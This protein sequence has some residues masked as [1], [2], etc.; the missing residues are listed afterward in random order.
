MSKITNDVFGPLLIGAFFNAILYG[1]MIMQTFVYYQ[2]YRGD[3]TWIRL[4][5][6]YLFITETINIGC[7]IAA[8]YEPLITRWGDVHA[9]MFFPLMIVAT[10]VTNVAISTPVQFFTAWRIT[11]IS[12]QKWLGALIGVFSVVS[13]I[14]GIWSA[15]TLRVV[16]RFDRKPTI[17]P[18]ATVWFAASSIADA[19]IT[20]ILWW[21]LA[22]RRTG[23]KN[24][25]VTINRIIRLTVQT[26]F[27]TVV[28]ALMELISFF[29]ILNT[30]ANFAFDF[31]LSKLYTNALLSTLN[32]RKGWTIHDDTEEE[33]V[34]FGKET[35][36][37]VKSTANSSHVY[38]TSLGGRSRGPGQSEIASYEMQPTTRKAKEGDAVRV[39]I[40]RHVA[41]DYESKGL[42]I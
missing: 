6:L 8:M 15:V 35:R 13:F 37:G 23:Y 25:D 28:F 29:T 26:G 17:V 19:L 39:D 4:F 32:A 38:T 41:R 34:L 42:E 9:L 11:V 18:K 12:K 31:P 33:N 5:V 22:K 10:P 24:T 30:N 1:V 21:S 2:S 20:G 3:A 16:E 36:A 40:S 27:L 7:N 14:F